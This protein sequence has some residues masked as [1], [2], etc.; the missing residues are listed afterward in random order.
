VCGH[1]RHGRGIPLAVTVPIRGRRRRDPH[2]IAH[3]DAIDVNRNIHPDPVANGNADANPNAD[4][5]PN[6]HAESLTRAA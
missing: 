1:N 5:E 4:T 6:T 2:G 3:P